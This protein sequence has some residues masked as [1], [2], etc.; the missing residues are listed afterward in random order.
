MPTCFVI[1]VCVVIVVGS[2]VYIAVM[3]HQWWDKKDKPPE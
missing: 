2:G 1:A 3:N